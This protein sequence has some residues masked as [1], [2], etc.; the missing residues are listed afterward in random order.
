MFIYNSKL[1]T[2]GP[3]ALAKALQA[4]TGAIV[5]VLGSKDRRAEP[6]ASVV[7]QPSFVL[8]GPYLVAPSMAGLAFDTC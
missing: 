4:S 7:G 1:L 6:M 8:L 2:S 3:M 5:A